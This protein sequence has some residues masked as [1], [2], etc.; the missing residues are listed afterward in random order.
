MD[1]I[2]DSLDFK[3]LIF[4]SKAE[5]LSWWKPFTQ[6]GSAGVSGRSRIRFLSK[7]WGRE[8]MASCRGV[9]QASVHLHSRTIWGCSLKP[10]LYILGEYLMGR[11]SV[12]VGGCL[13]SFCLLLPPHPHPE[14]LWESRGRT[15][16]EKFWKEWKEK[17]EGWER[18]RRKEQTPSA[19]AEAMPR[20]N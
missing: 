20:S 9:D 6:N 13:I 10:A 7:G 2:T 3:L 11:D 5:G 17:E 15:P 14:S 16:K 19:P 8:L 12:G 18:G 1:T 4:K